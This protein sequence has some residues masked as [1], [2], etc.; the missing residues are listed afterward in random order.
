MKK[1]LQLQIETLRVERF[2]VQQDST[3]A[4]GTVHAFQEESWD[5]LWHSYSI[6]EEACICLPLDTAGHC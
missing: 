5:C 1:K 3:A 2:E 4:R 6:R